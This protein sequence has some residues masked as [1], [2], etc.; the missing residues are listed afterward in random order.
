MKVLTPAKKKSRI[1]VNIIISAIATAALFFMFRYG[2]S[3][4]LPKGIL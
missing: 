3:M 4:I 2:F 1:V